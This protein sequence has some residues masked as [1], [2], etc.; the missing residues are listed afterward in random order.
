MTLLVGNGDS[1]NP[2]TNIPPEKIPKPKNKL[3]LF[4]KTGSWMW[5]EIWIFNCFFGSLHTKEQASIFHWKHCMCGP[6]G[7]HTKNKLWSH[8]T[9][10]PCRFALIYLAN[11]LNFFFA[12]FSLVYIRPWV[13]WL[14]AVSVCSVN[15]FALTVRFRRIF[16]CQYLPPPH[17][18]LLDMGAYT[19]CISQKDLHTWFQ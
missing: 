14:V 6:C 19:Y 5:D 7:R 11:F 1:G 9:E 16:Q 10:F 12:D 15:S 3:S 4:S 13:M 2:R 17:T 18:T 8:T